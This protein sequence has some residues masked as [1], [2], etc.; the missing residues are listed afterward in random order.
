MRETL[1]IFSFVKL[2][3]LDLIDFSG[4]LSVNIHTSRLL[5]LFD[6]KAQLFGLHLLI[7]PDGLKIGVE[8]GQNASWEILNK[9]HAL[10]VVDRQHLI[11]PM[12]AAIGPHFSDPGL[13]QGQGLTHIVQDLVA[14]VK[15]AQLTI[16]NVLL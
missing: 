5:L 4:H 16:I 10:L 15:V 1:L 14:V 3:Y 2:R 7:R 11:V 8:V 9:G 6:Q 13:L 12:P